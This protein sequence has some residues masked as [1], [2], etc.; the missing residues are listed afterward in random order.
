V[1]H[2]SIK[3]YYGSPAF[4]QVWQNI[5]YL[6]EKQLKILTDKFRDFYEKAPGPR[7]ARIRGCYFLIF[8]FLRYTAARISKVTGIDGRVD[9]DYR[10]ADVTLAVLKRHNS[11]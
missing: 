8:L 10:S 2:N 1:D 7:V 3:S 9:V 6:N 5:D 4:S 11:H